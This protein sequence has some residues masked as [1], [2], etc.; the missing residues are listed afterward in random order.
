[1]HI[2]MLD[3]GDLSSLREL[4]EAGRLA[5][6]PWKHPVTVEGLWG[7]LRHGHDG[8]P[9]VCF[10]GRLEPDGPVV[11]E[12]LMHLSDWDNRDLAWLDVTVNPEHRRRGLGTAMWGHLV[13]QAAGAG[14]PRI[15]ASAWKGSAGA[16]FLEGLGLSARAIGVLSRQHLH[17]LDLEEVRRLRDEAARHA[18]AYDVLVV[19]GP[20]PPDRFEELAALASSINDAPMDDLDYEDEVYDPVRL[21]NFEVAN[22]ARDRDL[23]RTVAVERATGAWVGHTVLVTERA[24]PEIGHQLDTAVM[25]EHRGHRLGLLLKSALVLHLAETRP[26]LRTVDTWN[27]ASNAHM[28]EVNTRLGYRPLAEKVDFQP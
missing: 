8:E 7:E 24:T 25:G 10:L 9:P 23:H 12:G 14:R 5:D 27:A 20:T 4:R 2:R 3:D 13:E 16:T 6:S 26:A 21:R 18:A 22:E 19:D 1:M 15:G 28:V 11:V 17:E